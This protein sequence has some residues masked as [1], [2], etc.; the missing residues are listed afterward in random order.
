MRALFL[1]TLTLILVARIPS[2]VVVETAMQ[3]GSTSP[4]F[5]PS[6]IR[7]GEFAVRQPR[8]SVF[9]ATEWGVSLPILCIS[10]G[11]IPV[12][13]IYWDYAGPADLLRAIGDAPRFFLVAWHA[14]GTHPGQT[15]RILAD[16]RG[17]QGFREVS[18]GPEIA[19]WRT[20][21]AWRFDRRR[22]R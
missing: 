3:N 4:N 1:A 2:L 21:R 7:L 6:T 13:E 14:T 9:L 15:D 22:E 17:L 5:E 8:D 12:P 10:N 11:E 16:A 18:V 19:Y 20:V